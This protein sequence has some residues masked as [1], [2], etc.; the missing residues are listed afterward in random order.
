[1]V[2]TQSWVR[3]FLK[4]FDSGSIPDEGTKRKEP[5]LNSDIAPF[6]E[7]QTRVLFCFVQ[8]CNTYAVPVW[9]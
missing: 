3:S 1:M 9:F 6:S 4:T 8:C 5:C 7:K 2:D